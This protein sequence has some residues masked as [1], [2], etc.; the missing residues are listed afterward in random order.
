MCIN[1]P[2]HSSSGNQSLS[3]IEKW[4]KQYQFRE[5][6]ERV[7]LLVRNTGILC[8]ECDAPFQEEDTVLIHPVTKKAAERSP[9]LQHQLSSPQTP[10]ERAHT[11][12]LL[13]QEAV[14][15]MH[16]RHPACAR[17][18]IDAILRDIAIHQEL[19][20]RR[21]G[22]KASDLIPECYD[23]RDGLFCLPPAPQPAAAELDEKGASDDNP[24]TTTTSSSSGFWSWLWSYFSK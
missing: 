16:P 12:T 10:Q 22:T 5:A 6:S 18:K 20:D 19:G 7:S 2:S 11:V 17:E 21:L 14:S 15:S 4:R 23:C 3:F 9:V 8:V 24:P 1:L 13:A